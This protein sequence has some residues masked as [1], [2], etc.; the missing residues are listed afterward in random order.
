MY[1]VYLNYF[2]KDYFFLSC[3]SYEFWKRFYFISSLELPLAIY[4]NLCI[5]CF[6][7]QLCELLNWHLFHFAI[8]M[9]FRLVSIYYVSCQTKQWEQSDFLIF[10]CAPVHVEFL[11]YL[12]KRF[13]FSFYVAS[14]ITRFWCFLN[15]PHGFYHTSLVRALL[16]RWYRQLKVANV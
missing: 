12:A 6:T 7:K 9:C 11:R 4:I 3:E 15:G 1:S 5:Y 14:L 8:S 16:Y 10:I 13:N 2:C